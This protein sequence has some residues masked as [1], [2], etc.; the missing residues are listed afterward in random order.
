M[1]SAKIN[2]SSD[3][4][5]RFR[6]LSSV[7][8]EGHLTGIVKSNRFHPSR[9]EEWK[10]LVV[11]LSCSVRHTATLTSASGANT[12][13]TNTPGVHYPTEIF[14]S[15]ATLWRMSKRSARERFT[16]LESVRLSSASQR[17]GSA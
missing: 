16:R 8:M 2:F 9:E 5:G 10:S 12:T 11:R 4:P 15:S 6:M 3:T 14:L 1:C 17:F 7:Q 13:A